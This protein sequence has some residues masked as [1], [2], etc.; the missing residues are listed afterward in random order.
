MKL[1]SRILTVALMML[2]IS[3]VQAQDKQNPWSVFI[4]ANAVDF[5]PTGNGS[6]T[7][8]ISSEDL[9]DDIFNA[10]DHW[11]YISTV[12]Q[13]SIGR[14]MSNGFSV[15]GDFAINRIDVIG[16]RELPDNINGENIPEDVSFVSVDT[17]IVYSFREFMTKEKWFDPYFG[18]GAGYYFLDEDGALT[19]NVTG[20][21]NLWFTDNIALTIES[22]YKNAFDDND[23]DYF[24]HSGGVTIAFGGTDTDGDGIY[25]KHDDCPNVKGLEEFNGCP[26]TDADGIVDKEDKC[27]NEAGLAEFNGCPDS[28]GDGIADPKDK[29]PND[30]GEAKFD[31]CPDTDGDGIADPNDEC[32]DEEGPK[33]NNGC[34]W[35]DSDG[36][37]VVDKDDECPDSAGIEDNYGCPKL[38]EEKQKEFNE[39][40][41]TINFNTG[42]SSITSDSEEALRAI[43]SILE[44]Y[45]NAKFTVEGHTDSVGRASY[46]K[47]LSDER[48]ASVMEY[49]IS[50]GV[51]ES[52]LESKGFGEEQPTAD[53]STAEGRAKNRRVEINLKK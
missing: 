14:Y 1:I 18:V 13:V 30:A 27:P 38:T 31:G 4:G 2:F 49:L 26:D 51:D 15:K 5:Y 16:D 32:P 35:P 50:N 17:E 52:R 22:T 28:D 11:N 8:D 41:K 6:G 33:E 24:Q 43:L 23:L 48:A 44:E 47:K 3:N 29:C 40:A 25:D 53:N 45:P 9:F 19:A 12:S 7:N 36:D 37:G 21:L 42:N 39:Y 46:N 34:P 20:G 10:S